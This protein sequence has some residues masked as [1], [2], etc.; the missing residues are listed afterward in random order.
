MW[1]RQTIY[2]TESR[3]YAAHIWRRPD[4]AGALFEEVLEKKNSRLKN[5]DGLKSDDEEMLNNMM[6]MGSRK[7]LIPRDVLAR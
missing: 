5:D 1:Q 2:N 7:W 4:K 6:W 3:D